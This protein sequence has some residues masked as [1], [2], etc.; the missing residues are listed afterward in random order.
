MVGVARMS[1]PPV[2]IRF[3][4]LDESIQ[5]VN[6]VRAGG[7]LVHKRPVDLVG[8]QM[9]RGRRQFDRPFDVKVLASLGSKPGVAG[10]S[11]ALMIA[12]RHMAVSSVGC[13]RAAYLVSGWSCN[14]A[15]ERRPAEKVTRTN[16][17][18]RPLWQQGTGSIRSF[19]RSQ[20]E[21]RRTSP[22]SYVAAMRPAHRDPLL[23]GSGRSVPSLVGVSPG[24]GMPSHFTWP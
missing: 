20:A 19:A 7:Q 1:A 4:S 18:A 17:G 2:S 24:L 6:P 3:V 5:Q 11:R 16:Q 10:Y 9:T 14:R 12:R 21:H 22:W 15:H 23:L 8:F 13:T